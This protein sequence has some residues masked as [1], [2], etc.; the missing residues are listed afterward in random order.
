MVQF[1][2]YVLME[3]IEEKAYSKKLTIDI[4]GAMNL[5]VKNCNNM[6]WSKPLF[7][8][9]TDRGDFV[10]VEG[11]NGGRESAHARGNHYTI[12]I[13]QFLK[14]N[15][16][17]Y[18]LRSKSIICSTSKNDATAYADE[19]S[20]GALY[21]LY[22]FNNVKIGVCE[23][24]DIQNTTLKSPIND[25][26][27]DFLDV[28]GDANIRDDKGFDDIV[29]SIVYEINEEGNSH[30]SDWFGTDVSY[31]DVVDILQDVFS[32]KG[33]GFS[34]IDNQKIESIKEDRECWIGGKCL[35]IKYDVWKKFK[36]KDPHQ[37]E[38]DL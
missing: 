11:Q 2:D 29:E 31:E 35:M 10:L 6:E 27:L 14:K 23:D 15:N 8:G 20:K 34:L 32:V 26:M 7:R 13:D 21:V 19:N 9:A 17:D 18:P 28:L 37:H 1:S 4:E 22:P 36:V 24:N 25:H 5:F 16:K 12:F 3:A 33:L 38:L 30:L